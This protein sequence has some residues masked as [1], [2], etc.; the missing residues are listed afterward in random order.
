MIACL[1]H[2]YFTEVKS[3]R[4]EKYRW[5]QSQ[6]DSFNLFLRVFAGNNHGHRSEGYDC[7]WVGAKVVRPGSSAGLAP[8]L[9]GFSC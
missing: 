2:F 6:S 3:N 5:Q 1:H 4:T 9:S 7:G 8:T